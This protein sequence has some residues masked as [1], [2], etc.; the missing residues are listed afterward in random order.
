MGSHWNSSEALG[1]LIY[2]PS[3]GHPWRAS[4]VDYRPSELVIAF[5]R[6][7]YRRYLNLEMACWDVAT[8]DG[9]HSQTFLD[10]SRH[11]YS[12]LPRWLESS[13]P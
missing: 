10:S 8:R 6:G 9:S 13:W 12:W 2:G 3:Y 7:S 11:H 1:W 4:T 5:E